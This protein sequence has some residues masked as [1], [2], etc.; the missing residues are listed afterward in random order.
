MSQKKERLLIGLM[1]GMSMDGVDVALVRISGAYPELNIAVIE[2]DYSPYSPALHQRLCDARTASVHEVCMLNVD[3]AEVFGRS[4]N[5][6]LIKNRLDARAIDAIGSHGQTLVHIPPH[7]QNGSSLQIGSPSV[8]AHITGILTVGNFRQRDM[9][10][11]GQGAPLVPLAEYLLFAKEPKPLALH[12]LG[13]ISNLTVLTVDRESTLAF[14]TGPANQWIDSLAARIPGNTSGI[15]F[16]GQFSRGGRIERE[17]LAT[18]LSHPFF[19]KPPPKSAGY[20]SFGDMLLGPNAAHV[21]LIDVLRTA[22]EMCALSVADAYQR[23]VLPRWPGLAQVFVSGGGVHNR[24]LMLALRHHLST[25]GLKLCTH[26][27]PRL[28]DA[29]EAVAFAILAHE[30]LCGRPGTIPA[31]TGAQRAVICGEIAP[32]SE[33]RLETP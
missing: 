16:N 3:L 24:T 14:D 26:Q 13:S 10:V 32:G 33:M 7:G 4:V 2:T 15:D 6:F 17:L 27:D 19:L 11:G 8:I 30:T 1:S 31:A 5:Q 25:I 23:F 29:K 9:A 22:V 28:T 21:P 12:N 18:W 20:E